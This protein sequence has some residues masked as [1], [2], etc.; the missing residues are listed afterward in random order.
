MNDELKQWAAGKAYRLVT[1]FF[2]WVS[3]IVSKILYLEQLVSENDP[4]LVHLEQLA[5]EIMPNVPEVLKLDKELGKMIPD[6]EARI[7]RAFELARLWV[8]EVH[9]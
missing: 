3:R 5:K 6:D 4:K 9:E 7:K 2:P 8:S 1:L